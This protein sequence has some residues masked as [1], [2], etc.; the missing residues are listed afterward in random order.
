MSYEQT[1][2]KGT[3]SK[4]IEV[5]LRDSS[6]GAGKTGVAHGDVTASYVREG[7]TRTAITLVA[8]TAG[9]AYSSGKWCEV[10]STNCPGIYQLHLPN[11]ALA[12][13]VD[14]V[15]ITLNATGAIDKV[16]RISLLNVD[17]RDA[18]NAGLSNLDTTVSSRSDLVQT[19]IVLNG[20][21]GTFGGA[22]N[23]VTTVQNV[24][25][26]TNPVTASNMRGTD[27]ALLASS[28][29]TNFGSLGINASGDVSRVT[30]CDTTT[31]NTDMRGTDNALP[32][33]GVPANFAALGI[34][35]SGDISRVTLVDTTTTNTDQ[36]G[37]DNAL[38]ASS[39]PSNFGSLGISGT[40]D[41]SRVTLVDTVTSNTDMRG[42]DGA[43]TVAPDN[44]GIAANGTAISNLNDID[45][46]EVENAVWNAPT[47][48][49]LLAGTFGKLMDLLKKANRAIDAEVAGTPTVNAFDTNLSGYADGAFDHELLV[50][51]SGTL[52]GEARPIL[53]YSSTN[54]RITFEEP[55]TGAPAAADE[56]IILPYHTTPTSV[57]QNGLA[58][59]TDL[60]TV[61]K[62]GV[63]YT[64]TA[65]SGD[66]IQVT[67]S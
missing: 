22:V 55:L 26:V 44:A 7:A 37:T 64:A 38:L 43:N 67:L 65:Q 47:A 12:T 58:R 10:D 28:A 59:T 46:T 42:T 35:G 20:A 30:L 62:T 33:S 25:N 1:I 32:S 56:F 17:L 54:G 27:N 16:V 41:V 4:I 61:T 60:A 31:T 19:D 15:T 40:G 2:L 63:Q 21:I 51:V 53:S 45:A 49:H 34:N 66:T 52:N 57:I 9:D 48:S 11:A 24:T 3:T 39:A 36:R 18:T 23:N 8:G 13:G 5:V 14:A 29:P 6:T 50:F